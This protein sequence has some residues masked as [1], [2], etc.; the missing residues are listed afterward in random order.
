MRYLS[1]WGTGGVGK[2]QVAI[3]YAREVQERG[4]TF[5]FWI[6]CETP[7]AREQSYSEI[8]LMLNLKRASEG[9]GDQNISLATTWLR[10][11]RKP[12]L[13]IFDNVERSDS[14]RNQSSISNSEQSGSGEEEED[15]DN[16]ESDL[17]KIRPKGNYGSVLVTTR[18]KNIAIAFGEPSIEVVV[19]LPNDGCKFLNA[20][21]ERGEFSEE[22]E[23]AAK[24]LST[25]LGG[26]PLAL[27]QIAMVI[28]R[29]ESTRIT[30]E[31][32]EKESEDAKALLGV[33]SLL[34][35][36]EIPESI[37][38]PKIRKYYPSILDRCVDPLSRSEAMTLLLDMSITRMSPSTDM[39][40]RRLL[41]MEYR[42]RLGRKGHLN[43]IASWNQFMDVITVGLKACEDKESLLYPH[44]QAT[45]ASMEAERAHTT[46]AKPYFDDCVRIRE[47][48]LPEDHIELANIYASKAN[49][50]LTEQLDGAA[51]KAIELYKKAVEIDKSK[52]ADSQQDGFLFIR[53]INWGFALRCRKKWIEAIEMME[54]ARKYAVK[55]FG[56]NCHWE[57]DCDYNV[58][59]VY[60]EQC[61]WGKARDLYQKSLEFYEQESELHPSTTA[62][63]FKL[64]CV[65]LHEGKLS[66]A[67][68]NFRETMLVCQ[69]SEFMKGD[70][71][72]TARVKGRSAE[73][74][75]KTGEVEEAKE[76]RT[77]TEAI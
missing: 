61:E 13:I 57:A 59:G 49:M 33:I 19:F 24:Q 16:E 41:Q 21:L 45:A 2:T 35:P 60:Y 17:R 52:P 4:N 42:E 51:E 73:A 36:E 38:E 76:L 27:Y 9:S 25:L 34:A 62:A 22:E 68:Q 20:A 40:I 55:L 67:I 47:K 37:F 58:A 65:D 69:I 18:H 50:L 28:R 64:A 8:A 15:D 56:H 5:I 44:L 7:V 3:S 10:T 6:S 74:L 77:E 12:W 29:S 75:E 39:D 30:F 31:S 53:Y 32:L 43:E 26:L 23:A 63:L 11:T 46:K 1:L 54:L 14:K 66:K 71:G 48:L 72:E 70:D